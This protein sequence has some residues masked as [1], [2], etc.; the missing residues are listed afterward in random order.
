MASAQGRKPKS[1]KKYYKPP[2]TLAKIRHRLTDGTPTHAL[3]HYL[4]GRDKLPPDILAVAETAEK[5]HQV[6]AL[7][8]E[9]EKDG[10]V[11]EVAHVLKCDVSAIKSLIK[12]GT[13]KPIKKF[14]SNARNALIVKTMKEPE[15]D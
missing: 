14:L 11:K 5:V 1:K 6:R 7:L 8:E 9:I 15:E 3:L 4:H 13:G 12:G 10:G 2:S